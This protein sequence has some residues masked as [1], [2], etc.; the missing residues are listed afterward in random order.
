M[1]ENF[2]PRAERTIT[3]LTGNAIAMDVIGMEQNCVEGKENPKA[4]N[5][6][7]NELRTDLKTI[8]DQEQFTVTKF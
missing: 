8:L 1:I 2:L 7:L 3:D 5:R 4:L 6:Y